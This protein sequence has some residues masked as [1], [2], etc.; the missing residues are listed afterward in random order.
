[1]KKTLR[2][3][4][5]TLGILVSTGISSAVYAQDCSTPKVVNTQE[6]NKGNCSVKPGQSLQDICAKYGIDSKCQTAA[7]LADKSKATNPCATTP[8]TTNLCK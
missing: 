8:A 6:C 2:P 3:L 7:C 1:M 5:L 4:I